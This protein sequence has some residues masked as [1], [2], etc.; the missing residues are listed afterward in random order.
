MVGLTIE[1]QSGATSALMSPDLASVTIVS[2]QATA[3]VFH[4]AA[5]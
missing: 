4:L 1:F 3:L 2:A 5:N